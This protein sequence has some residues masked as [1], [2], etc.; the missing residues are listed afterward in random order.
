MYNRNC[1][2]PDNFITLQLSDSFLLFD[3]ISSDIYE[4]KQSQ[5]LLS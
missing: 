2:F 4:N 5:F 1:S 3:K